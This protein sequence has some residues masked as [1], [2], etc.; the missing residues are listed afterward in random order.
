MRTLGSGPG[1][2]AGA[3][4]RRARAGLEPDERKGRAPRDPAQ[5]EAPGKR[6][7]G[8]TLEMRVPQLPSCARVPPHVKSDSQSA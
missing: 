7:Y 8:V 3:G 4:R 1:P 2:A 6:L 5:G